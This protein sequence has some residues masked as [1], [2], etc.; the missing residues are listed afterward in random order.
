MI[1]KPLKEI[2]FLDCHSNK[3]LFQIDC[4]DGRAKWTEATKILSL[5]FQVSDNVEEI[6]EL[7]SLECGISV[8]GIGLVW[9]E[10]N[11]VLKKVLI[12]NLAIKKLE[13]RSAA[14]SSL[15]SP[16]IL[17]YFIEGQSPDL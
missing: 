17:R 13:L 14:R 9:V 11:K 6:M 8:L 7:N 12:Y 15:N 10:A 16:L 2:L 5:K 1:Y 3:L 4:L